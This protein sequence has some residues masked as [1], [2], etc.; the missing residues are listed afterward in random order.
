MNRTEFEA[1][2][3][4]AGKVVRGDINFKQR[5]QTRPH[6]IADVDIENTAGYALRLMIRYNPEV[7][8]KTF[9]VDARGVG[10]ICRL[11]VDGSNHPGAGRQHKHALRTERCP[12]RNLPDGVEPRPELA[13]QSVR[14]CF[15]E[16]CRLGLIVHEGRLIAPD[17][18]F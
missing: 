1:L 2:R 13:G 6:F 15:E 18:G 12:D 5:D 16:F 9:S 17:E 8:S 4:V 14:K 11:D 7:G 10:P 3:D